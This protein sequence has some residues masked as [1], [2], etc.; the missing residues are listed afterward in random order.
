MG[1]V[2]IVMAAVVT[3]IASSIRVFILYIRLYHKVGPDKM[4]EDI[5][6]HMCTL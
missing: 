4:F 5:V 3:T 6:R 2:I 1:G